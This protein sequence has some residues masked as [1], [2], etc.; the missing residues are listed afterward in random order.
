L[1]K[2]PLEA[3]L[4]RSH[5]PLNICTKKYHIVHRD[6]KPENVL[7]DEQGFCAIVDF[8]MAIKCNDDLLISNPTHYVVGTLP[9]IAPELLS[10]KDHSDKVD[11]WSLGV[12]AFEFYHG[13][14]PFSTSRTEGDTDKKKM[15]NAIKSTQLKDVFSTHCPENLKSLITG[16]LEQDPAKCFCVDE[17]KNHVFFKDLK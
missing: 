14:R 9:Y 6:L 5:W 15:V 11:W 3:T 17:V 1:T 12:M 2:V 13:R 8:N 7:L 16:L 10:G 4:R